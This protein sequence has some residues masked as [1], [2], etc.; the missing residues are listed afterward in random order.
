MPR[1]PARV[2]SKKQNLGLPGALNWHWYA[3]VKHTTQGS[4]SKL[5][6]PR[7]VRTTAVQL[8]SERSEHISVRRVTLQWHV[9]LLVRRLPATYYII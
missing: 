4:T 2:L 9:T 1:P 8:C 5:L 6:S 7:H 3:V